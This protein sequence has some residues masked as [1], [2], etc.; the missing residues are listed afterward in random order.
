M[1]SLVLIIFGFPGE[2]TTVSSTVGAERLRPSALW[3]RWRPQVGQTRPLHNSEYCLM[4]P[5][6]ET[7]P[8]PDHSLVGP[9]D[10]DGKL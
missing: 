9:D 2:M 6:S 7:G 4:L 5:L 1:E 3:R 10:L 8:G